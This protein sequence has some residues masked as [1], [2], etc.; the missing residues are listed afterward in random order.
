MYLM[1]GWLSRNHIFLSNGSQY[2][3]KRLILIKQYVKILQLVF[4]CWLVAIV[5][6][7]NTGLKN[8][9]PLVTGKSHKARY[10]KSIKVSQLPVIWVSN[11]K[12][13][14]IS[15]LIQDWIGENNKQMHSKK[16]LIFLANATSH[17]TDMPVNN[18]ILKFLPANTT[19]AIQPVD[20]GIIRAFKFRHRKHLMIHPLY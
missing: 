20:Q 18:V 12:D 14:I 5:L 9:K 13:W 4:Y 7:W 6:W 2:V 1:D 10:F 19:S 16:I 17:I 15:R 8:L 11:Q 3:E